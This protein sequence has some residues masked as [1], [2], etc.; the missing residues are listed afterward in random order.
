V[1]YPDSAGGEAIIAANEIHVPVGRPVDLLLSSAD[2]IHA[3]WVPSLAGKADMIPGRV[4]RLVFRA[5]REG[6]YRGQ[7]SEYCG[8][9]HAHMGLF[10]FAM[11]PDAFAAWR[12]REAAP[13]RPPDTPLLQAGLEA[14]LAQ[15]CGGCHTIRGEPALGRLGPDLTHVGSRRSLGAAT[16]DNHASALARFISASQAIKPGNLMRSFPLDQPIL[17]AIAAYLESLK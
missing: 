14:F 8:L 3:F 6:L 12:A 11:R 9:Q 17:Q 16:L 15:G 13:A 1:R 4:T 10:V 5:D 7:C 2:V